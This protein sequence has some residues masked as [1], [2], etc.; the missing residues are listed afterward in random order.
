MGSTALHFAAKNGHHGVVKKLL[1]AGA[2][3]IPDKVRK[4]H[5]QLTAIATD[6]K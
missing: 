3:D 2:I 1:T 5:T 6:I 4:T